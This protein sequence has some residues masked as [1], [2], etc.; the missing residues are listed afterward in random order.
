MIG[1][2]SSTAASWVR[3]ALSAARGVLAPAPHRGPGFW[4]VTVLLGVVLPAPLAIAVLA[5]R[6][7]GGR[8]EP[9]GHRPGA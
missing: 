4:L 5:T 7:R 2:V 1:V 3:A 6:L 9:R 8:A